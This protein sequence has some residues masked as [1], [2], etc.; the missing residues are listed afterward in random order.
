MRSTRA[1]LFAVL[2]LCPLFAAPA[3]AQPPAPPPIPDL[4]GGLLPGIQQWIDQVIP[5]PPINPV[6]HPNAPELVDSAGGEPGLA[7]LWQATLPS[8]VGDAMF[9]AWPAGLADYS[10]GE[11]IEVRDVTATAGA[12]VLVPFRQ[13]LLLKYRTTDAHGRPSFAT[14]TLVIPHGAW[15]GPGDRPVVVNNLPI[16]GLGR[17]CTPGYSLAHGWAAEVSATDYL[18]PT[19]QLA[20]LRGYAALIPDHQGPWMAYAEPYVA[21]HAILDAVRA[22]RGWLPD[23]FGASSFGMLG[24]SGGAIATHGAVKL[25]A[26]Y[27]PELNGVVVGAAL[28]GVPADYQILARSMN[29]NLAS[30][31][32]IGATFGVARERPEIL[33]RMN[34]LAQWLSTS[35]AKDLC[36]SI[37]GAAGVLMLPIDIAANF[38]DPLNSEFAAEIY[39][40]TRMEG[41]KSAVPLYIYNGEQ[42]FW[43]PAEGARNLYREQC[44]LGASAVY[45]GVLGEHVVGA[46]LGYPEAIGWLDERLR[47]V[48]ARSEC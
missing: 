34:N 8:N 9:D 29:A 27:A 23:E 3:A 32:F 13:A 37:F 39:R 17:D 28:G 33:G 10:P 1:L 14:A 6:P 18:P 46:V 19:T 5:P 30:A 20:L 31:V 7:A 22:V 25:L 45:R 42:E 38:P 40:V 21:G 2:L 43:I 36:G 16:D 4:S 12:L 44:A 47:G 15:T 24:Y 48:P 11:V 41:M 35:P 26:R